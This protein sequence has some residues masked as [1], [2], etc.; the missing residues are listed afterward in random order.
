MKAITAPD[1]KTFR[2]IPNIGPAMEKDFALLGIKTPA[3]LAKQDP[4]KL[5]KKINVL[6]NSRVDPCVLDTYMAA[7]DFMNGAKAAPWWK[8]TKERKRMY[9]KL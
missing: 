4:Y 2:D 9:P 6:T 1:V 8:Y 5:Y 7:I 3:A